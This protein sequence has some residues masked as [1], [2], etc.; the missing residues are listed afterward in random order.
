MNKT[1]TK[2]GSFVDV[3]WGRLIFAHTFPDPQDLADVLLEEEPNKRDIAFYATDPQ[4]VLGI[5]PQDLFLDPSTTYRLE[6]KTWR[7][8]G[9][10]QSLIRITDIESKGDIEE[11]NRI[12]SSNGMVP[13][14]PEVAWQSLDD[15]RFDY[16]IARPSDSDRVL[17]VALVVDHVRCFEDLFNSCSLW[18]LAVDAQTQYP[19]VGTE[20]VSH[21]ATHFAERGRDILDLSVLQAS[22]GAIRLYEG[23]GFERVPVFAIK[24]R[25]QINEHLYVA[26]DVKEGYNPYAKIIIDEA[27]RRGI[28]VEPIDPPRGYFRLG[29][30]NRRV[31]CRES[32]SELTSSIAMC[33]CADKQLTS[34]LLANAGLSVPDQ[35]AY[36]NDEEALA[37]LEKHGGIVVKPR[38]GEQ[39]QGV[40]VDLQSPEECLAAVRAAE[41]F[42][43]TV[44]ME[45]FVEGIDLRIIVINMVVVAAAIRKPAE[46]MGT[47]KHSIRELLEKV[48]RR[49]KAATG[50]ES[51]IPMDDETL[52]CIRDRG[53]ELDDCLPEGTLLRV[54]RTANLH[55]GGTI[56]DVTAQL[57]D[58]LSKA[59]VHAAQTLEIPV[60]GLDFL[61]PSVEGEEYYIVEANERPGLANHEPQPTA[62]RF[63]DLLFPYLNNDPE[64]TVG[65]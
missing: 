49:R 61:V 44:L 16:Y 22:E 56:H 13:L 47:G 52:R 43:D 59:A 62:E 26:Q 5:A 33:R 17:G 36:S 23:L 10:H 15:D 65:D 48:S 4:L 54:R 2:R 34:E 7:R 29:V 19:A 1:S 3:G 37:F 42:C 27:L 57:S 64:R 21:A 46:I 20:L 28:C 30:G 14:D 58:D 51:Q 35:L 53:Y 39:G 31:T 24:R 45:Q 9:D 18:A 63:I 55:T 60:V 38:E 40:A 25:N 8:D 50:G 32:L 12:Y 41:A 6:L 11:I